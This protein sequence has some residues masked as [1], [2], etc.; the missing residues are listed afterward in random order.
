[1][2]FEAIAFNF[3]EMASHVIMWHQNVA[4]KILALIC[5]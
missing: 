4:Q 2:L 5:L 1:M 3:L